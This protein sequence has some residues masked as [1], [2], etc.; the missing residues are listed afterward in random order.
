MPELNHY[1]VP[2]EDLDLTFRGVS[3]HDL[4][5]F[6]HYVREGTQQAAAEAR[7]IGQGVIST[8][9]TNLEI[10][11]N[12]QLIV[13]QQRGD[14]L[15]LTSE[16]VLLWQRVQHLFPALAQTLQLIRK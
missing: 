14:A 1:H 7:G 5:N 2:N 15:K 10:A 16:G 12:C 4:L 3:F 6:F 9:L 13:R 11:L 8:S